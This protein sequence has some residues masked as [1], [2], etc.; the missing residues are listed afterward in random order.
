MRYLVGVKPWPNRL[1]QS[2]TITGLSIVNEDSLV[3]VIGAYQGDDDIDEV[4]RNST[5]G[6]SSKASKGFL[7]KD[8]PSRFAA[9]KW[10]TR[11]ASLRVGCVVCG[12]AYPSQ[13]RNLIG[14]PTER[15]VVATAS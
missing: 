9:S 3:D 1:Y 15:V 12:S 2:V 13:I 4:D 7:L 8:R 5:K 10:G 6:G 11:V 14:R